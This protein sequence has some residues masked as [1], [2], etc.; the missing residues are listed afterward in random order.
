MLNSGLDRFT[1]ENIET[2]KGYSNK[3]I[4]ATKLC[5]TD[6]KKNSRHCTLTSITIAMRRHR[7]TRILQEHKKIDAQWPMHTTEL[8]TKTPKY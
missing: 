5:K 3:A 1:C 4:E 6:W 2:E 7:S 8:M